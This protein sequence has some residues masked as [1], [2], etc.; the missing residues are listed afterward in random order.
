MKLYTPTKILTAL[1][2]I[3]VFLGLVNFAL[4]LIRA[5]MGGETFPL[6]YT[7]YLD[8]EGNVPTWFATLL[9]AAAAGLLWVI[10]DLTNGILSH[11]R[12][13]SLIFFGLSL[14]EAIALHDRLS[15]VLSPLNDTFRFGSLNPFYNA[16]TMAALP[17]VA[18]LAILFARFLLRLPP[19]VRNLTL[20]AGFLYVLGAVGGEIV[21][22]M[23]G[24][25]SRW[26]IRYGFVGLVEETLEFLGVSLFIY[27]ILLHLQSLLEGASAELQ[28]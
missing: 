23:V 9:L 21:G 27:A 17:L 22:G 12:L 14:D 5:S 7:L 1:L 19:R 24:S 13:L 15:V 16:W 26:N 4:V 3:I 20:L 28:G 25:I 6:F 10:A 18:L 11:W 8:A 2:S